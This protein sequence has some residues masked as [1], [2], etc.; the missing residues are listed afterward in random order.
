MIWARLGV[1]VRSG[2]A[3]ESSKALLGAATYACTKYSRAAQKSPAALCCLPSPKK[4]SATAAA[5]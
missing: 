1:R 2:V 3:T 5:C 4:A